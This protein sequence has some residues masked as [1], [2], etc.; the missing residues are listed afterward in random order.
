MGIAHRSVVSEVPA[1][2]SVRMLAGVA[3]ALM[4]NWSRAVVRA[5]SG[6]RRRHGAGDGMVLASLG[7]GIATPVHEWPE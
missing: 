5:Q 3:G 6:R 2:D 7:T 1:G 4:S